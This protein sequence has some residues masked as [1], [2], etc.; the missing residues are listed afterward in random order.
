MCGGVG[1]RLEAPVEKPLYEIDGTAMFDRVC[2]ALAASPCEQIVAATAPATPETRAHASDRAD[3]RVVE[4]PGDGYVADLDVALSR[5]DLD[6]PVVT[7]VADLPLLAPEHV[8]DLLDAAEDGAAASL[9]VMVPAALKRI[10]GVSADTTVSSRGRDLAPVGLNVVGG[11]S[12][13]ATVSRDPRLA[14][15][16]NRERDAAVAR[17]LALST[18]S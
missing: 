14:V 1:A 11:G 5:A 2:D 6:R 3:C 9:S 18:D 15:N 12:D 17:T 16:V 10:L 7:C 13:V 4:T 8:A